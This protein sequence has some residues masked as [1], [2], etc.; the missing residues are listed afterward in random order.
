MRKLLIV[1]LV[2]ASLG[3]ASCGAQASIDQ[4]VSS[5]GSSANLQLHFTG[6]VSGTGS[7]KVQKVLNVLSL[8]MNYSNPSGG[9][10]SQAGEIPNVEILINAGSQTLADVRV[11]DSNVYAL[12]NISA[13]ASV[14]GVN[15]P[16]TQVASMQL[17][18]GGRWFELP[19]SLLTSLAP[20][21]TATA[22]AKADKEAAAAR[23]IFGELSTLIA[24]TPYTSLPNGGYSE[25][26]TLASVVNAVLPTIDTLSGATPPAKN[27][28]GTYTLTV[29]AS[30]STATGGSITV[31]APSGVAGQGNESVGLDVSVAHASVDVVAP[32]GATIITPS[33]FQGL[34]SQAGG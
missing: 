9:A 2:G 10:L 24:N 17:L 33:L 26:G 5:L 20:T 32:S 4:A 30:G 31:T 11:V 19:K 34:L 16:A 13:V 3:L 28:K 22:T 18:L 23:A 15:L 7:A 25:T 8:D 27:V 14:P 29:T 6:S 1:G 12:V 21:P